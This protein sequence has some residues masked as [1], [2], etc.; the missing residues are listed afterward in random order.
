MAKMIEKTFIYDNIIKK[1]GIMEKNNNTKKIIIAVSIVVA[2]AIIIIGGIL[3]GRNMESGN[4]SIGKKDKV[5]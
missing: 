2:V 1:E 3:I 4:L 5:E